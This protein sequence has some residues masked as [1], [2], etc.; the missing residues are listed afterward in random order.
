MA[1]AYTPPGVTVTEN[2]STSVSALIASATDICIVG[3]A[4]NPN[5]SQTPLTTTDVLILSGTNPVVLPTL[6]QIHNDAVL[7]SILSVNDVIN[8]QVGTPPGTGYTATTD[9]IFSTGESLP[10]GNNGTI[11]RVANGAIADG[12]LVAVTYT[13][14]PSDYWNPIRLYDIGSVES[15][16]GASWATATSAS[17]GQT[18]YTGINSQISM[19]ARIAFNNGAP[20][21]ICQPLFAREVP[22]DPS[23]A[24][25]APTADQVGDST[26]WADTLYVLR[27]ITDLEV[28][29][30]IIGQNGSTVTDA[31]VLNVFSAVQAYQS[32]M[33]SEQQYIVAIFGEDGTSSASEAAGLVSTLRNNHAPYLQSAYGNALSS[34][35]ALLNNTV[36]QLPTPSGSS[37]TINVGGQYAAAAVAGMLA[38]RNVAQSLTRQSIAGFQSITDSRVPSD[39]NNDAAAGLMVVETVGNSLIRVRQGNTLDI[40]SGPA[41]SELSVVRAKF[42]MMESIQQTL[43]NQIIGNIIADANSPLVVRSAISSVLG[44]LQTAGALVSYSDVTAALT[45]LNPTTISASFNY[46]PSFPLNYVGV[47]FAIDMTTN[48]VTITGDTTALAT[49]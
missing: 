6:V 11:T 26:T 41:R 45:S 1:T 24:Q 21:V 47:T 16:F 14:L 12:T 35:A 34:Q 42:V 18:Y 46:K 19:A 30:P 9:Y 7:V 49:T 28:I 38:S 29:V 33:N 8:P 32:Y 15:R 36:F 44:I 40:I 43:D 5:T 48:T 4:G 37:S 13:Y 3:L 27:P 20:S 17:T 31:D 10:D 39:K 23:S 2:T 22:G 25:Q